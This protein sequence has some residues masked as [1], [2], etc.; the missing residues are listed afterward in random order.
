MISVI[1]L[2]PDAPYADDVGYAREIVV[3]SLVWLV[4][5]VVAGVVR[6]VTLAVPAGLGLSEVADQ[7]GCELILADHEAARLDLALV[8]MRERRVLVLKTGFQPANGLIEEIDS[9]VRRAPREGAAL[10]RSE[11]ETP[12]ARLFPNLAPV[13]GVLMPGGPAPNVSGGFT[14]LAR[15]YR[16]GTSLRTRA[17]RIT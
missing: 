13:V 15:A 7:A 3:R 14:R 10:V 2:A 12:L 4:S 8:G 5:A 11:P 17:T 1:V 9:F 16:R 6:D